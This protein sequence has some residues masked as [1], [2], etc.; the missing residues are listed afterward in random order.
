MFGFPI[1]GQF[2]N[3]WEKIFDWY[4]MIRTRMVAIWHKNERLKKNG[5]GRAITRSLVDQFQI[6]G[7]FW[8]PWEK[9]FD[10][11]FM[12]CTH[13]SAI[14]R[15]NESQ[16]NQKMNLLYLS[17]ILI[18]GNFNIRVWQVIN[19]WLFPF[20]SC[21]HGV[22]GFFCKNETSLEIWFEVKGFF[23]KN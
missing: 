8:S 22:K 3:P 1:R 17:E 23:C 12:I 11:Y 18:L 13:M 19:I 16:V 20:W 21:V 14:W 7:Q 2:W 10:W 6:R 4:F 5:A 9:I 15:K